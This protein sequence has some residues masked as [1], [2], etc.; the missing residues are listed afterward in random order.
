MRIKYKQSAVSLT[1]ACA[2]IGAFAS[3][4]SYAELDFT[5]HYDLSNN[6][7]TLNDG[8]THGNIAYNLMYAD[9]ESLTY[10]GLRFETN[11]V[12]TW[13]QYTIQ[14]NN[15]TVVTVNG[16]AYGRVYASLPQGDLPDDSGTYAIYAGGRN[17]IGNSHLY[18]NGNVDIL[19]D[20]NVGNDVVTD[21][22]A[23]L[24]YARYQSSITVGTADST[25]KLWV[26][27]S[28]PDLISA[29]NGSSVTFNS[30]KN[31]LIG[32]I[33]MMDDL[34]Q[35]GEGNDKGNSI[36]ITLSGAD[37]Y[38]FGDEKTWMNSNA[39][40]K[41]YGDQ[42]NIALENGAQWTY[43]GL[44]YE[45]DG[46]EAVKKRLSKVTL[47][48]GIINLFD[49]N[50]EEA[51]T[52]IGLWDRLNNGEYGIDPNMEHDYVRI[53]ELKGEGGIFRLDL[54]AED[55]T[56]SDMVFIER[57]SGTHYFEPYNLTL[58]ESI[59]PENTLTFALTSKDSTVQFNDKVNLE[60]E[61]LF[62]YE[63]EINSRP[64]AA[65]DLSNEENAYWD[66]TASLDE[67]DPSKMDLSDFEGGT[68]WFIQRITLS[69][70]SAARAMT[71]AGYAAYD[72][73]I[74]M[75][76]RD[77]RLAETLR[78][79][80]AGNGLWVRAVHGRS[81]IDGQYR[82]D[83][84]GVVIGFDRTLGESSTLGAWFSY[85]N[86]DADLLDVN[87]TGDLTRYEFALYDTLTFGSQYL[88][89]VGRI[90]R[91]SAEFDAASAAYQTS[92]DF[93]Q[94]YAAVSAEYG[95]TLLH[96]GTGLFVEPQA[97]IQAA[98]LKSYDYDSQRGMSVDADSAA[99]VLGRLGFRA[100]KQL[101]D[102]FAAGQVYVRADAL[103]QFTDGQDA[104]FSD[105]AGHVLKTS[106]GDRGTWGL[107]G[108]GGAV[109][110]G[111]NYGLQLDVERAFG[112][113]VENTWLI[114]G[115][116]NWRF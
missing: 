2:L 51:W 105:N 88:D 115:R 20:H 81:G 61:T 58:L 33:D 83:R 109:S 4:P 56:Q 30:T 50:I 57:G 29:K 91:V 55:K 44:S 27:A 111:G 97:Q 24:F 100:G 43:F 107:V 72:A 65:E 95:W 22:G 15:N 12:I 54:N 37:S 76:R 104:E 21:V 32:S 19:V 93:D 18:L 73:A 84:S 110:W 62:D 116:F 79:A 14:L 90:G 66:K 71:G 63:L 7:L 87:G 31:Q 28:Q 80:D 13:N 60:G 67:D 113:D 42:F 23:N 69:E 92:G 17:N 35:A 70:S 78:S 68:N 103:H 112:G 46:Y 6:V 25:S 34:N 40:E 89:F 82:W 1:I 59:T 5:D 64:I 39:P 10:N 36:S 85:T 47:N 94:D 3:A 96:E 106:W 38:W 77:R 75:D 108:F 48:G 99:S 86:G 98:Y 26:I 101:T 16:D 41:D 53:G 74:E 49:A 45:R 8:E 102:D 11:P 52:N 114:A 9:N